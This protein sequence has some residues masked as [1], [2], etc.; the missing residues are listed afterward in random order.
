[1]RRPTLAFRVLLLSLA[2]VTCSSPAGQDKPLPDRPNFSANVSIPLGTGNDWTAVSL[3]SSAGASSLT[4]AITLSEPIVKPLGTGGSVGTFP[5]GTILQFDACGYDPASP[6]VCWTAHTSRLEGSESEGHIRFGAEM[7]QDWLYGVFDDF[8]FDVFLTPAPP[9]DTLAVELTPAR[10]E[11]TP[12][13]AGCFNA[14][15]QSAGRCVLDSTGVVVDSVPV[16]RNDTV[17]LHLRV[18]YSP[19]GLPA[20]GASVRIV[21]TSTDPI[22]AHQHFS[23]RPTGR[24]F[25]LDDVDRVDSSTAGVPGQ[26]RLALSEAADTVVIYRTTG[27]SGVER[28]FAQATAGGQTRVGQDSVEVRVPDLIPLTEGPS[29]VFVG[30]DDFH[31]VSARHFGTAGMVSAIRTLADTLQRI[32]DFLATLPTDQRPPGRFPRTLGVN[33]MSLP[34]GGLFDLDGTWHYPHMAHRTGRSAD[35]DVRRDP[36][37]NYLALAVFNIW[38]GLGGRVVNERQAL[39]H[40]HLEF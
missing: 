36:G 4:P 37:D 26:L 18:F 9:Q 40:L 30:T 20:P 12:V 3:T 10:R 31:S 5:P 34:W 23:N 6:Y 33:D 29:I 17:R 38:E 7:S 2:A 22:G 28:L 14:A 32:A 8:F 11:V 1:M 25:V 19:S 13:L 27:V 21:T 15:F 39:N 16:A 35:L 24:F